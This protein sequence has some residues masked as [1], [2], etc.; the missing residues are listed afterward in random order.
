MLISFFLHASHAYLQILVWKDADKIEPRRV[1]QDIT[2]FGWTVTKENSV[3]PVLSS[4]HVVPP[5]S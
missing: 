2:K 1:A 5:T 4:Q 3:M